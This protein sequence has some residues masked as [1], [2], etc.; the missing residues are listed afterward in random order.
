MENKDTRPV[1]VRAEELLAKVRPYIQMHSGD[2]Q[3]LSV[4]NGVATL[5]IYGACVGCGLADMTYNKMIGGLLKQELPEI[6]QV[7]LES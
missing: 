1:E 2:V 3:L 7:V 5:K 4:K 6:K